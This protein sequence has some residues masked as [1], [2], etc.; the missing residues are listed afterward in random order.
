MSSDPDDKP[1]F[2]HFFG[3]DADPTGTLKVLI[4]GAHPDDADSGAGGVAAL[5]SQSGHQVKMVSVTNGDAGHHQM[6][7]VLLAQRRRVEAGNAGQVL[8]G[9]YVTLDNHDCVLEPTLEIRH[10]LVRILREF[11]P[12]LVMTNRPNDY[13]P[14]HRYTSQLVQDAV[15]TS[16]VPNIVSDVPYNR[17]TPVVVYFHDNFQKPYP[18]IPRVVIGIDSVVEQKIDALHSHTSQ[19]YEFLPFIMRYEDQVPED[20]AER[21]PWLGEFLKP[22]Y[23]RI[24]DQ[25]RDRLIELYGEERGKKIQFAEAF[26]S[27]EYGAPLLQDDLNRLFPYF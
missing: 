19:M 10:Q 20:I 27:C 6:G 12:D 1:G 18:F 5:Y 14:D 4:I 2:A 25:Y 26:E 11:V 23:R 22:T 16:S 17:F 13:H 24:A 3:K 21:R 7:G 8:G 15:C 9:E